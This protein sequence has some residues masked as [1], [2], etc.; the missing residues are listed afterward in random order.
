MCLFGDVAVMAFVCFA[1]LLSCLRV[2]VLQF[3]CLLLLRCLFAASRW[4]FVVGVR[5]LFV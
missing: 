3:A 2:C 5:F 1:G 4:L